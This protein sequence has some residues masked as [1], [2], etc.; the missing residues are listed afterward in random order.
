MEFIVVLR[1]LGTFIVEYL[2]RVLPPPLMSE[3]ENGFWVL[4]WALI[5]HIRSD[6]SLHAVKKK[7]SKL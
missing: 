7:Y 6:L 3:S 4:L 5:A 2:D 1:Y